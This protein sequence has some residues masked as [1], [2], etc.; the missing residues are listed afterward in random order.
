[1]GDFEVDVV[2]DHAQVIGRAAVGTQKHEVLKLAIREFDFAEYGVIERST[3][4][5]WNSE[6]HRCS[7]AGGLSSQSFRST[8]LAASAFIL[9]RTA[10]LGGLGTSALQFVFAAETIVG[11]AGLNQLC[12]GC[13]IK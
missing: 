2:R 7:F 3:A 6:S 1:M 8:Q 11:S 10:F 13:T 4:A 5:L 12:G 9:R